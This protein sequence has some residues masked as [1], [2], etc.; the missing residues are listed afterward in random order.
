M[1]KKAVYSLVAALPSL[2]SRSFAELQRNDPLRMAGATAFFTIFALPP[3]LVML[4]QLLRLV[5]HPQFIQNKL[6]TSLS[7]MVG[8]QAVG[9]LENVLKA[10][11]QL[12]QNI[13][14]TAGGFLFLVFVATNLFTII[15]HSINQIWK[16]KPRKRKGVLK[17][18][19]A[20]WHAIAVILVAGFLFLI[21]IIAEALQ[22]IIGRQLFDAAPLL[23]FY[24]KTAVNYLISLVIVTLW[25][26]IMFRYLPDGRPSWRVA[27]TGALLTSLLFSLGRILLR[28]LLSYSNLNTLY[29][30]SASIVLL[31]LFVFYSSLIL[32]F[33]AAF[34][35]MWALHRGN[36]IKPLPHAM[37]YKLVEGDEA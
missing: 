4:I 35:K 30:T 36:A 6:F 18:M 25:F 17:K 9:Q 22:T 12:A 31:L 27:F 23:S 21:G 37:H 3:I 20:R 15:R 33:G 5:L 29:G 10:F 24:F 14:V 8:P 13:W 1:R 7:E 19:N 11:S 16:I 28:V 26:A 34:T 32:Y 2:L